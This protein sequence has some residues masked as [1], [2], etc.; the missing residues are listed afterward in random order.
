MHIIDR[1]KGATLLPQLFLT[2]KR[3]VSYLYNCT[4]SL[5]SYLISVLLVYPNGISSWKKNNIDI[6][7]KKRYYEF[8][9]GK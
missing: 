6:G 7:I 3:L 2:C 5:Y 9:A 1:D 8:L 4:Q